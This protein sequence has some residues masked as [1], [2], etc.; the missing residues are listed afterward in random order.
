M[1]G[2]AELRGRLTIDFG[3]F[4]NGLGA[5]LRQGAQSVAAWVNQHGRAAISFVA[6][7]SAAQSTLNSFG[8]AVTRTAQG[9][10][11]ILGAVR[12]GPIDTSAARSSLSELENDAQK[13]GSKIGG[14]FGGL[15]GKLGIAGIVAGIGAIGVEMIQGNATIETYQASFEVL[16]GSAEKTQTLL[17]D[18]K[19]FGAST[20]FEFPELA[21]ASRNLIA[22]GFGVEETIPELKKVG[23][24]ASGVNA[25]IGEL[26]ELYGKARVQGTLYAEDINQLVGRGIPVIQEFAKQ[27]GVSESEVKKMASEG[28]ITFTNLQQA[29]TDL[30]SEG[31]KF[32]GM[33]E[34]QGQTFQGLLST[35]KD[36]IGEIVRQLGGPLFTVAKDLL[37]TISEVIAGPEVQGALKQLG[38]LLGAVIGPLG[39]AVAGLIGPILSLVAPIVSAVTQIITP[40]GNFL[41][42]LVGIVTRL[43]GLLSGPL[44]AILTTVAKV[45][46]GILSLLGNAVGSLLSTV[47][48]AIAPIFS[49]VLQLNTALQPLLGVL[50]QLLGVLL[51]AVSQILGSLLG[52]L[53]PILL[54]LLEPIISIIGSVANLA[55]TILSALLPVITLLLPLIVSLI[56]FLADGLSVVLK[57]V[58]GG[59]ADFAALLVGGLATGLTVVIEGIVSAIDWLIRTGETIGNFLEPVISSLG[60]ELASVGSFLSDVFGGIL[61]GLLSI[62]ESIGSFILDGFIGAWEG[63]TTSVSG[64]YTWIVSTINS[65]GIFR[66]AIEFVTQKWELL[67]AGFAASIDILRDIVTGFSAFKTAAVDAVQSLLSLDVKG[68]FDNIVNGIERAREHAERLRKVEAENDV[69]M[70]AAAK[71]SFDDLLAQ[72]SK[73]F[74][75]AR[76]VQDV[77]KE[78]A[79]QIASVQQLIDN[80]GKTFSDPE[81]AAKFAKVYQAVI[82]RLKVLADER[83]KALSPAAIAPPAPPKT[84]TPAKKDGKEKEALDLSDRLVAITDDTEKRRAE[85]E[86][87]AIEDRRERERAELNRRFDEQIGGQEKVLDRLEEDLD[88]AQKEKKPLRLEVTDDKGNVVKVLTDRAEIE[89]EFRNRLRL[90]AEQIERQRQQALDELDKKHREDALKRAGE[91]T[92]KEIEELKDRQSAITGS[93]VEALEERFRLQ[94]EIQA[95]ERTLLQSEAEIAAFDV[96]TA[97]ENARREVEIEIA[98]RR[99]GI[100]RIASLEEQERELQLLALEERLAKER[101]LY[102]GNAAM[103]AKIEQDAAAERV[104]IQERFLAQT[105]TA[106]RAAVAFRLAI[107]KIFTGGLSEEERKQARGKIENLEKERQALDEDHARGRISAM[108]YASRLEEIERQRIETTRELEGRSFDW[109][110]AAGKTLSETFRLLREDDQIGLQRQLDRSI[111]S[112][113]TRAKS[114]TQSFG[115]FAKSTLDLTVDFAKVGVTQVGQYLGE[116]L[117]KGKLD[118]KDFGN[119]ML[120]MLFEIIKKEVTIIIPAIFAGAFAKDPLLGLALGAVAVG[121][122]NGLLSAAQSSLHLR[123]GISSIPGNPADGDSVPAVLMPGERVVPTHLNRK[124]WDVLEDVQR[125]ID[126]SDRMMKRIERRLSGSVKLSELVVTPAGSIQ[127]MEVENASRKADIALEAVKGIEEEIST[128]TTTIS[129]QLAFINRDTRD[130]AR[131]NREMNS[132]D[133]GRK[134]PPAERSL[135]S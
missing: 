95:R 68:F 84:T 117:E 5:A 10:N 49:I 9:A 113:E 51:P 59:I 47:I 109:K 62:L 71:K 28:K 20:P 106:Y 81:D 132:R 76:T 50:L 45:A 43:V 37:K 98:A 56:G 30:T 25:P 64:L 48:D 119:F 134:D 32:S 33:M 57:T 16:T 17:A 40:I 15:G 63:L 130:T 66:S 18:I 52:A 86:V 121:V 91:A 100:G 31:G 111:E 131:T 53:A 65:F 127:R 101:E 67:K 36:S 73:W 26:A 97:T 126:P 110:V 80:V 108:E 122:I 24:I 105:N 93:T 129:A 83:K 92:K 128:M 34:K 13:T 23:D 69:K 46:S 118:L 38:E 94:R 77:D 58:A 75:L 14:L 74:A 88:K 103:L 96:K 114:G 27:L 107:E 12:A 21:D 120:Q 6:N 11:A 112:F 4:I 87:K 133:K 2:V 61:S 102:A 115:E 124:Y 79:T 7:S 70:D 72:R 60:R 54:S 19:K 82:D 8:Q 1:A 89:T 123:S 99:E 3:G 22:F 42:V 85:V 104:R 39:K 90:Q 41:P 125:D 35:F 116:A 29:F 55:A 135:L 78:L 44:S